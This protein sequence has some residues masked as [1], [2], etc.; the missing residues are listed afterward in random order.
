MRVRI[1][2]DSV[3]MGDDAVSHERFVEVAPTTTLDE[4]FTLARPDAHVSRTSWIAHWDGTPFAVYSSDW[5]RGEPWDDQLVTVAD[6]GGREPHELY[7]RYWTRIDPDWLIVQLRGGAPLHEPTLYEQWQ[8]IA[9]ERRERELREREQTV[10]ERLLDTETIQV[11]ESFGA[12]IDL[13]TDRVCRFVA[14]HGQW[15]VQMTDTMTAVWTPWGRVSSMRPVAVVQPWLVALVGSAVSGAGPDALPEPSVASE[16][17]RSPNLWSV[18]RHVGAAQHLG[19]LYSE[20]HVAWFQR[21]LGLSVD[22]VA[23]AYRV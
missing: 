20:D 7:F 4:L 5:G 13:H 18:T 8:P 15:D 23:A 17:R 6:L 10:T 22:E 21:T 14:A 2:R 16:V 3:A 11:L 1:D 9:L 12:R 19:Q